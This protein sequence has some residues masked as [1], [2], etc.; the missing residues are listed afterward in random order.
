[1]AT[2]RIIFTCETHPTVGD[3][4]SFAGDGSLFPVVESTGTRRLRSDP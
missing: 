1:M 3:R 2:E 4:S